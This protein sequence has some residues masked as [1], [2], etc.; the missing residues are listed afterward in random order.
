MCANTRSR[1]G[2]SVNARSKK[3]VS[4]ISSLGKML[5][6]VIAQVA[7]DPGASLKSD[8]DKIQALIEKLEGQSSA[9]PALLMSN[10][11]ALNF[12]EPHIQQIVQACAD[13][14]Q[15]YG[16]ITV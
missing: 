6:K 15:K 14:L 16:T 7:L 10:L 13:H 2:K 11:L 1:E 5:L 4:V 3:N 12:S 9:S 8:V